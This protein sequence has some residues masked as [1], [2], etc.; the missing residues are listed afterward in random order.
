MISGQKYLDVLDDEFNNGSCDGAIPR[1][2]QV[3]L[4]PKPQSRKVAQKHLFFP[5][6]R[7]PNHLP[8]GL[9][10]RG[11]LTGYLDLLWKIICLE[12]S[13]MPYKHWICVF[14]KEF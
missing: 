13:N 5:E 7:T 12:W 1:C 6:Q 14:T 11:K 2:L 3:L 9:G 4:F 10:F 8:Q